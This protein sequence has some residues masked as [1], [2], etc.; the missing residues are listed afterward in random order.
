M[1]CRMSPRRGRDARFTCI[2]NPGNVEKI[3]LDARVG[4]H[5]YFHLSLGFSKLLDPKVSCRGLLATPCLV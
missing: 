2:A 4:T 5:T 1:V 3:H